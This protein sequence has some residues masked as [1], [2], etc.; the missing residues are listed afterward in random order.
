[1]VDKVPEKLEAMLAM[2]DT[3]RESLRIILASGSIDRQLVDSVSKLAS[4][5]ANLSRESL[6]WADK[7]RKQAGS[8]S[9]EDRKAGVIGFISKLPLGERQSIY[10]ALIEFES[11]ANPRLFLKLD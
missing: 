1:M 5:H 8:A 4:A 9:L 2:I 10:E 7:L 3:A 6:R 11:T